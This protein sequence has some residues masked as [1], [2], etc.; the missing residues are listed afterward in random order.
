M[1]ELSE[2]YVIGL[3]SDAQRKLPRLTA[4]MQQAQARATAVDAELSG[5][6]RR[7]DACRRA[8]AGAEE[9]IAQLTQTM[10]DGN[11]KIASLH[12]EVAGL[13]RRAEDIK[14]E[15]DRVGQGAIQQ[16]LRRDRARVLVQ[17]EDR[18]K[19]I[20]TMRAQVDEARAALQA[21]ETQAEAERDR[22]RHIIKELD[23]LQSQLPRPQL[24]AELFSMRAGIAHCQ[25]F[26]DRDAAAW[27]A[28][29]RSAIDVMATLHRELKAGKYRLD[30][31]SDLI[32]GRSTASVEAAYGAVALGDEE[33]ALEVFGLVTDPELFFH[34]IFNVFRVWCLGLW[35]SGRHNELREL[36]RLHRYGDRLRGGYAEAFEGL[37][38]RD[39]A[40][41]GRGLDIIVRQEWAQSQAPQLVRAAGVVNV[42]A[43]AIARLAR[44][45]GLRVTVRSPTVPAELCP[46]APARSAALPR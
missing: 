2:A 26:L 27:R 41:L 32:G 9:Q 40:M 11:L 34:H 18:D 13:K 23:A 30:K 37:V 29:L 12:Q 25:M 20:A 24:F 19:A 15:M 45:R 33:L 10:A 1:I 16:R 3:L 28:E 31:N 17:I 43:I 7:L 35:L 44:A 38:A 21:A 42:G 22:A 6:I 46:P 4:E 39:E 36:L 14:T 8:A 5:L